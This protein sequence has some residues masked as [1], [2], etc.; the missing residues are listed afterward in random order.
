[1]EKKLSVSEIKKL[2]TYKKLTDGTL[3]INKYKGNSEEVVVPT[4]IGNAT[5]SKINDD[6]FKGNAFIRNVLIPESVRSIGVWVFENCSNLECVNVP[7]GVSEINWG[8]F[9]GCSKLKTLVLPDSIIQIDYEAFDSCTSLEL[10]YIPASTVEIRSGVFP[11]IRNCPNL[12]IHAPAGSYAETYAKENNI[13][14]V[15]E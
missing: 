8:T 15:A 4:Q 14:F 3:A 1:M 7:Q 12:T 6:A 10:L 9:S 11:S 5:V 13:P 2:W